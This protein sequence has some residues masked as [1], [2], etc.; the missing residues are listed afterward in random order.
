MLKRWK[1]FTL[2]LLG[3]IASLL[4][5]SIFTHVT[6]PCPPLP[7]DAG[8]VSF[9]MAVMHPTDLASNYQGSLTQFLIKFLVGFIIA[10]VLL[11]IFDKIR[12]SKHFK[13]KI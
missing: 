12:T 11:V 9:K 1:L 2:I 5:A 3:L 8:C 10:L 4:F 13:P 7:G 6:Y